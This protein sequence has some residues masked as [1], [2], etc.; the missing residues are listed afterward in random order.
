MNTLN[1]PTDPLCRKA[2]G[3]TLIELLVVIAIIA[4][5]AGLLLPALA[6]SK[7]KAVSLTC[8]SNQKQMGLA[9]ALYNT[10]NNDTLAF[11]NWDGDTPGASAGW[12]YKAPTVDPTVAPNLTSDSPWLSGLW[13]KYIPNHK[14]YLCPVDIKSKTYTETVA[15]GGRANKL[16]SYVMDGSPSGFPS[17]NTTFPTCKTVDAWSTTCYLLWE[18]D[19]NAGGAGNPGAFEFNDGSNYPETPLGTP[20]GSEGIGRLHSKKGGNILSLD[21]HVQFLTQQ[22]FTSESNEGKGGGPGGKSYLWWNPRKA[23]GGP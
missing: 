13:W 8:T 11:C 17:G 10:D 14:T 5:L 4:I 19:E 21:G 9:N 3:F 23:N 7:A 18:P 15:Q 1:T 2:K 16:S 6:A 20:S 22:Q 12:L